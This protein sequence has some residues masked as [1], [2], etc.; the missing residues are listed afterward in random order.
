MERERGSA[1]RAA[2]KSKRTCIQ[3]L[4]TMDRFKAPH[5]AC[6]ESYPVS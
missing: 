5:Y 2:L 1:S 4:R 6:A 3:A